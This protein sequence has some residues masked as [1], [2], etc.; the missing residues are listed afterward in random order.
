MESAPGKGA[1]VAGLLIFA[2]ASLAVP[3]A[4]PPPSSTLKPGEGLVR[5]VHAIFRHGERTPADTYP[6]DPLINETYSPFGWG[7][8]TLNGKRQVYSQ[9]QWLRQHYHKLVGDDYSA[10]YTQSTDVDR[11]LMT[12]QLVLAAL[13]PPTPYQEF[14]PGLRWQPVPVHTIPVHLDNQL[15]LVRVPCPRYYEERDRVKKIPPTSELLEKNKELLEKWT[16]ITGLPVD[17]LDEVMSVYSTLLAQSR[18]NL[19]LPPWTKEYFPEA[20]LN[21]TSTSFLATVQTPT[22]I[23]LKAGPLVNNIL[24]EFEKEAD[25][26]QKVKMFLY[27][28]HDSTVA[29]IL[30][31]LGLYKTPY[32]PGYSALVLL[33]LVEPSPGKFFVRVFRRSEENPDAELLQIKGCDIECPLEKF[34]ELT[35]PI[36]PVNWQEECKAINQDFV[37]P[38]PLPP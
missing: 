4:A 12:A 15:L 19:T 35:E 10:A 30:A 18:F 5:Q 28:G 26:Q 22:L 6:N 38:P 27:S 17:N 11:S 29:N 20:F 21:M 7:Q 24:K 3:L 23:R 16:T 2:T 36:R 25:Q 33:E 1:L 31:A 37:A 8:L 32:I 13:F 9:G 34:K 14:E